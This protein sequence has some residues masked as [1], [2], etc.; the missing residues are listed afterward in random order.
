M[1]LIACG[2]FALL[3][4]DDLP[5]GKWSD[6]HAALQRLA[7]ESSVVV[8]TPFDEAALDR[9]LNSVKAMT[10]SATVVEA[11]SSNKE[12]FTT[13]VNEAKTGQHT[14]GAPLQ[15]IEVVQPPTFKDVLP[16]LFVPQTIMLA[17]PYFCTFGGEL[18]INAILGSYYTSHF[19]SWGQVK[20]GQVAAI[21]G[22]LNVVTRPAGGFIADLIYKAVGPKRGT[23]AKKCESFEPARHVNSS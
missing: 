19:P 3:L 18:A 15:L 11:D 7:G 17:A 23:T 20:S 5:T 1:I 12:S 10:A 16:A 6:R 22:L 13:E 2:L 9:K 4:C 21:F 14:P 8:S